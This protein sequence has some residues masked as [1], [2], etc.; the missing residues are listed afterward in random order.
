MLTEDVL[1]SSVQAL[2]YLH[3][4]AHRATCWNYWWWWRRTPYYAPLHGSPLWPSVSLSS[5]TYCA[6]APRGSS[7]VRKHESKRGK[8][9]SE[10]HVRWIN[11]E[12]VMKGLQRI[13]EHRKPNKVSFN[14][15]EASSHL[16][17]SG[18]SGFDVGVSNC[19]HYILMVTR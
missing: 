11:E 15:K 1:A 6:S 9:F 18:A 14:W 13:H 10:N 16:S 3:A 2:L 17:R 8:K 12:Q 7:V 19:Q 5:W 4:N